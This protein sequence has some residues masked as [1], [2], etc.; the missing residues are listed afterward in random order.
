MAGAMNPNGLPIRD[1]VAFY[2]ERGL[3]PVPLFGGSRV[4]CDCCRVDCKSRDWGKHARPGIEE[5]AKDGY[6]FM[7]SE[8]RET[9]NVAL[10]MGPQRN[11]G[12]ADWLVALDFDGTADGCGKLWG[13]LAPGALQGQ[14]LEQRTPGGI[15]LVYSVPAYTP[16]GNW[17]D[18]FQT[19]GNGF[20][21][22]LRYARGRIVVAPS[23][24]AAG[25]YR[26]LDWREPAAL[27]DFALRR[28]LD[29]RRRRGLPVERRWDRGDKRP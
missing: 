26:W 29:E 17:V 9:D 21:L 20:Q 8:F 12:R 15:H 11:C 18:V 24:G 28:I 2:L 23:R 22:D 3:R 7:P 4:G 25:E 13:H 10:M 16:L 1:A 5:M 14:T 19:R 6:H 27:P